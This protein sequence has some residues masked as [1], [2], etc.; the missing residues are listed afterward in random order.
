MGVD[1]LA[2]KLLY[3]T[4]LSIERA[5][6]ACMRCICGFS[7]IGWYHQSRSPATVVL[8]AVYGTNGFSSRGTFVNLPFA[9]ISYKAYH[10]F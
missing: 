4:G 6:K 2:L 3:R 7:H 5:E 8:Q 9:C 10:K 1:D